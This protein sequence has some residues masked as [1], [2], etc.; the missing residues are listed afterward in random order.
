MGMRD[1][2]STYDTTVIVGALTAIG[3]VTLA[4]RY[5]A[6]WAILKQYGIEDLFIGAALV[7]YRMSRP[8]YWNTVRSS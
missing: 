4:L 6:R 7:G 8:F 2:Y 5:I 3:I 1:D